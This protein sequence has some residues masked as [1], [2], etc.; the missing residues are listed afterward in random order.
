MLYDGHHPETKK[1][2]EFVWNVPLSCLK[3]YT[4]IIKVKKNEVERNRLKPEAKVAQKITLL[5]VW[6]NRDQS[7]Q[8]W[9]SKQMHPIGAINALCM[10]TCLVAPIGCLCF[11]F[12]DCAVCMCAVAC[13]GSIYAVKHST[14][15]TRWGLNWCS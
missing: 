1:M 3:Y 6:D 12:L 13:K 4:N 5:L 15:Y 11:D 7:A 2:Q 8:F 14:D 9:E 10:C